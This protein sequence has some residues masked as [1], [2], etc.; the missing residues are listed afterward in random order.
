MINKN[1]ILLSILEKINYRQ[2]IEINNLLDEKI[3]EVNKSKILTDNEKLYYLGLFN[4]FKDA[5]SYLIKKE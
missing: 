1:K 2:L 5:L 3:N 4:W